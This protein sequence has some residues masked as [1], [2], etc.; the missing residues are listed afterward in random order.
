METHR[1]PTTGTLMGDR[2][3]PMAH[4]SVGDKT[5]HVDLKISAEEDEEF[6]CRS[7]LHHR[8]PGFLLESSDALRGQRSQLFQVCYVRNNYV[9]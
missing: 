6:Y 3:S 7:R 9:L 4:T 8:E 1:S 2:M 5:T